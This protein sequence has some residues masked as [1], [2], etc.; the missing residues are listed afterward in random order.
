[1]DTAQDTFV[2][3]AMWTGR[4]DP[5]AALADLRKHRERNVARDLIRVGRPVLE[6][7]KAAPHQAGLTIPIS[8]GSFYSSVSPKHHYS[9]PK[10]SRVTRRRVGD[11][12]AFGWTP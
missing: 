12:R 5:V 1:M 9:R 11:V 7:W 10:T 4:T 3:S 2:S 8:T 6:G